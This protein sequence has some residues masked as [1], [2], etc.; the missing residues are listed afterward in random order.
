[1]EREKKS[2]RWGL[3]AVLKVAAVMSA[4][5]ML[6]LSLVPKS[7]T[8]AVMVN[9]KGES[10]RLVPV[11]RAVGIKLFSDGVLVVGISSIET[12]RGPQCPGRACGLREGDLI[13][14][15]NGR[16]VDTIEEVQ[17]AVSSWRE[18][19]MVIQAVRGER[20]LQFRAEP[21]VNDK[22]VNQLG[23]WLRDSMAGIGTMTFYDP[24]TGL[25]GALGHGINDVDTAKLMPLES[26]SIM[27]A[28]VTDVKRGEKG[29]PGELHGEFEL[30]QDVGDLYANTGMGIFGHLTGGETL[31]QME[32]LPVARA[33][34]VT[35]GEAVIRTNVQGDRV[36]EFR[37]RIL[38][39]DPT[40]KGTRNLTLEITDPRLLEV[41]G[42]IVQGMSGSPIIQDGR[43]VGAVTHVL[44]NDPTRGY[45]IFIEN[46]LEAAE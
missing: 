14:H 44:V 40:R 1:M 18:E 24:D 11:G 22:G 36:E 38:S 46:M 17:A 45:G 42:G 9:M 25:F 31:D 28:R 34:E 39:V 30:K 16:E 15:I 10:K 12:E 7:P 20:R 13:T 3:S 43:L 8:E 5:L 26:G 32:A 41:T 2:G 23:V 33:E 19:E 21:V 4:F 29:C 37:V 6:G 27:E 35:P